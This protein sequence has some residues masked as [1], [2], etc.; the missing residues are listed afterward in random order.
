MRIAPNNREKAMVGSIQDQSWY[1]GW[2]I[3]NQNFNGKPTW[4]L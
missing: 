4:E 3:M 2:Q 1:G